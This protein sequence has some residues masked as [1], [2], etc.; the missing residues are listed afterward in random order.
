MAS[1]STTGRKRPPLQIVPPT[2]RLLST[3]AFT[4]GE[5]F[6]EGGAGSIH[7]GELVDWRLR[8]QYGT[9]QSGTTVAVKLF[10]IPPGQSQQTLL[11]AFLQEVSIMVGLSTHPNIATIIGY[12]EQPQLTMVMKMYSESL[13]KWI[14]DTERDLPYKFVFRFAVQIASGLYGIPLC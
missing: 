3:E 12:T 7:T 11:E 2:S 1:S 6:A 4:V 9:G 14:M 10:K 8:Q 5:Q 13:H